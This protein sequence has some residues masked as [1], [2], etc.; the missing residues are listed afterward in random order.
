MH[1]MYVLY[2]PMVVSGGVQKQG[3]HRHVLALRR[4][5]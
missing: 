2:G 3:M 1:L 5:R 4:L